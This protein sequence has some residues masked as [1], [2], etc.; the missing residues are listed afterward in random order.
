MPLWDQMLAA[1]QQDPHSGHQQ[2]QPQ[3]Q[4]QQY[5]PR[6]FDST[7]LQQPGRPQPYEAAQQQYMRSPQ[8]PGLAPGMP[9]QQFSSP[10]GS[11]GQ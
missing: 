11:P 1:A 4:P 3:P 5:L 2:P 7:Q 10:E 9:P 8:Q 6:P